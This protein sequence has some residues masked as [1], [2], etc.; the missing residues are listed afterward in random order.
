[1]KD[2]FMCHMQNHLADRVLYLLARVRRRQRIIT[3]N[4]GG[5]E[6]VTVNSYVCFKLHQSTGDYD[7]DI[8]FRNYKNW[9][10][11]SF[12]STS[13]QYSTHRQ[14]SSAKQPIWS[15]EDSVKFALN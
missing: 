11:K 6:G 4:A 5:K 14:S 1:M 12:E 8:H 2:T 9:L 10:K 15:L 7:S 3:I 13:T